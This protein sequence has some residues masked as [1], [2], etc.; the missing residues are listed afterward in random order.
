MFKHACSSVWNKGPSNSIFLARIKSCRHPPVS[1]RIRSSLQS[2]NIACGNRFLCSIMDSVGD[3]CRDAIYEVLT[4][5][6]ME[7]VGKCRLLSKEYNKLTYESLFIK[8]HSQRTNIVSG[9]LIQSMIRKEYQFSFV[10]TN[11]LNTHTQIPF[12]FLP[13]HVEIVSSTNQGILLCRAHNKSCYYVGNLSIQ[14]WKKIPNPKTQYDTI[15]SGLMIERSKPLRYKIVRFLKPKFRLHKEFYMY[16]YIRVELFESATRKWKLLDEVKLPHEESLHRMTKVSVNGSLHWLTW[17]R[18]VFAFDVKRESHC[19][20]PLPLP[21]SEGNDNKDVRLTKYKGKLVMTCIDRERN[22]MEVWIM[23]DHDRKK[24]SKR[25]S[26]NI[27]VLTRKEP[28][29]SPFGLLQ[30]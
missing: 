7:T 20:L 5:S 15:E 18:N 9:F 25:H 12:D 13:D 6:S 27:G 17:K 28:H 14:Q 21:A 2:R 30:C 1:R 29:I 8:L 23:E 11:G 26:I 3:L 10:S 19:L 4:R 16:H 24:R 22:F